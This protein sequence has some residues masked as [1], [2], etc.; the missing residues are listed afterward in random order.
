MTREIGEFGIAHRKIGNFAANVWAFDSSVG[1]KL[2]LSCLGL[3]DSE[4]WR[5]RDRMSQNSQFSD[6]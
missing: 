2:S 1:V 4:N 6:L 3:L 5:V